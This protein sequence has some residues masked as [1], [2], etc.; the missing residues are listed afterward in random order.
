M[1]KII[2]ETLN[3]RSS[4]FWALAAGGL[5][6][7]LGGVLVCG[8]LVGAGVYTVTHLTT[9][10]ATISQVSEGRAI[11]AAITAAEAADTAEAEVE[12]PK[13]GADRADRAEA[14]EVEV[15]QEEPISPPRLGNPAANFTLSDLAGNTVSLADFKGQPVILNFWATWCGPCE[16]EMPEI[17]KAYLKHK[18]EGL[19]VLA[20]NLAEHPDTVKSFVDYYD[21]A[22]TILLDRDK[23]VGKLYGARAL[24]TTY[25]I[26]RSGTIVHT[27]YGQMDE[28]AL[29]I[30]LRKILP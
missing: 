27:Y 25:F 30:G 12:D 2:G 29:A 9:R 24:P 10:G 21:L 13:S 14:G 20:I 8:L 5:V 15:V 17:N 7:A 23:A 16:A 28:E 6:L 11:D 19:V 22:F 4:R 26:D 18:E 3:G 1:N